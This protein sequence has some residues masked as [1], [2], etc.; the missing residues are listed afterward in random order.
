MPPINR[1]CPRFSVSSP[2]N[3]PGPPKE[4]PREV[5]PFWRRVRSI[6]KR[7]RSVLEGVAAV[8]EPLVDG[9]GWLAWGAGHRPAPE[10]LRPVA[11]RAWEALWED[12]RDRSG[13]GTWSYP[14]A[15][16][17]TSVYPNALACLAIV[18]T[19]R[20]WYWAS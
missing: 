13:P 6:L 18:L 19:L 3:M 9:W 15:T 4:L 20:S 8:G 2:G 12:G 16:R 14:C 7:V 1:C 10:P 17:G 5:R 11:R